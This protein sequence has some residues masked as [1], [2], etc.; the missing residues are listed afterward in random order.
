[1]S[2]DAAGPGN[3]L[4]RFLPR[5]LQSEKLRQFV[6]YGVSG[7]SAVLVH[8]LVLT[9]L[10]ELTGLDATIA[11]GIGFLVGCVV[12]YSIQH[13]WVFAA[14]GNHRQ[15]V[16]RYTGVTAATFFLNLAIF[17]GLHALLGWWYVIAQAVATVLVFLV[18]FEINR[19][20]TFKAT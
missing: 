11:T 19:R 18:N 2:S 1:M 7:G 15:F 5:A 10:V 3:G 12:N 8:F 9:A 16:L 20:F 6:K 14:S 13:K 4:S 17:H